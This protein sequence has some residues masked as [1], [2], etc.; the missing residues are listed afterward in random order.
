MY[1]LLATDS[2]YILFYVTRGTKR[3]SQNLL[4]NGAIFGDVTQ[5]FSSSRYL[6]FK[7]DRTEIGVLMT[8]AFN[9]PIGPP[10]DRSD[11]E[12]RGREIGIFL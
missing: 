4:G 3:R 9:D 6:T 2:E 5:S 12:I 7:R 8:H 10:N 11:K 1:K